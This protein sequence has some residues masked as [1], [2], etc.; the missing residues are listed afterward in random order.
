M[1]ITVR[2]LNRYTQDSFEPVD[3]RNIER[4]FA[5]SGLMY[6]GTPTNRTAVDFYTF[7]CKPTVEGGSYCLLGTRFSG[8]KV[9]GVSSSFANRGYRPQIV[10][11]SELD[12][13]GAGRYI[14]LW[15]RA[16]DTTVVIKEDG[17]YF[18]DDKVFSFPAASQPIGSCYVIAQGAGGSGGCDMAYWD[19]GPRATGGVGGGSGAFVYMRL[20]I[21]SEG[22]TITLPKQHFSETTMTRAGA[23]TF[24]DN[25][26]D[27]DFLTIYG[28]EGGND[29]E[30]TWGGFGGYVNSD[31]RRY[32]EY[33]YR[34]SGGSG[35]SCGDD[36]YAGDESPAFTVDTGVIGQSDQRKINFSKKITYGGSY[37]AGTGAASAICNGPRGP[38]NYKDNGPTGNNGAGG[39]GSSYIRFGVT[40]NHL[41]GGYGGL[42]VLV[43]G[44]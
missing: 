25:S 31:Y 20:N 22:I 6:F 13:F 1:A 3:G 2:T 41:D 33:L 19:S 11:N 26:S 43:I 16:R 37:R 24:R 29:G 5:K 9:D 34:K 8:L 14:K 30:H 12:P 28:G 32:V 21:P 10:S 4:G 36:G 7:C 15:A 39:S 42:A 17:V 27:Y 35:G 40:S 44:Y 38:I 23:M 18:E